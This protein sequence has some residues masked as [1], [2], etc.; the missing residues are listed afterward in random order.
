[1]RKQVFIVEGQHDA[2]KLKEV[3]G[4]IEVIT[5]NGSD[6]SDKT[7]KLINALDE[8]HDLIV[9]TDPDYAG[10]RI[11]QIVSKDLKHVH[12]AFLKQELAI[13]KNQ[14]K[15]G[16]EHASK[17]DILYALKHMQLVMNDKHLISMHFLYSCGLIGHRNSKKLRDY[18]SDKLHLGHVNGKTLKTR[19]E[20][21]NI[22]EERI[23]EVMNESST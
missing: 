2:A 19:L 12:H 20:L 4:D 23:K 8:A 18:V 6:I 11:R 10:Q 5:T 15:I 17:D 22:T 9:F 14:K 16:I 1:M 13:S 3:L 21:F 7:L